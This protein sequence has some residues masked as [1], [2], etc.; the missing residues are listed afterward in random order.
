MLFNHQGEIN[1]SHIAVV[2]SRS[3]SEEVTDGLCE[4]L[5]VMQF[6]ACVHFHHQ[7]I[8]TEPPTPSLTPNNTSYW[9]AWQRAAGTQLG[10][11]E[12]LLYFLLRIKEEPFS[13]CRLF[14]LPSHVFVLR[15]QFKAGFAVLV[16][17]L[18]FT[19]TPSHFFFIFKIASAYLRYIVHCS[20]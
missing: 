11:N 7:L 12:R 15:E 10:T 20:L 1:S 17:L 19:F 2:L 13:Q 18:Y 6:Q 8:Q 3:T 9:L 14:F 4:L 16:S 5:N